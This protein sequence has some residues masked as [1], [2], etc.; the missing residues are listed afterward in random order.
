MG[1]N[2]GKEGNSLEKRQMRRP[3]PQKRDLYAMNNYFER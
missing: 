2:K 3:S 1:E